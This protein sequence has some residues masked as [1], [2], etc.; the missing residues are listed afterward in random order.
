M[1][2]PGPSA[3]AQARGVW[4]KP[5]QAI[6][7]LANRVILRRCTII[8]LVVGTILSV[9][10][11]WGVVTSGTATGATW[12]RVAANYVIPFLV[13]GIGALSALKVIETAGGDNESGPS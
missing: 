10:N 6:R 12:V 2:E 8:A 13:S 1:S 4:S 3:I 7:L 5:R 11:Q 9:V